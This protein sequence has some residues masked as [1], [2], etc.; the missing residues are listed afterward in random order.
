MTDVSTAIPPDVN[1]GP[2]ILA[3]CGSM[4]GL[5]LLVVGLRMWYRAVVRK[6]VAWDDYCMAAAMTVMF[7]EMMII[8]PEVVLGAGRHVQFI[9]PESNIAKGLHLNFVTQPLSIIA[10]CLTKVSVGLFLLRINPLPKFKRVIWA[11]IAFTVAASVAGVFTVLFQCRP[12]AFTWDPSTPGGHC[13]P[14]AN[15]RFAAFFN[16]SLSVLTDVIFSLLPIPMIWG[17]QL[18]WR[19]KAAIAALLSLG[20]FAA[21]ASI[22]RITYIKDYGKHG[23]FLFDS[24][25]L[26]IW[27][28]VEICVAIVAGSMPSLKPIVVAVIS[29]LSIGRASTRKRETGDGRDDW[30]SHKEDGKHGRGVDMHSLDRRNVALDGNYGC[31]EESAE[32][33]VSRQVCTTGE[34][35]GPAIDGPRVCETPHATV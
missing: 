13:I 4:V 34:G 6:N 17:V 10:L 9:K 1:R 20:L 3:V 25:N 2:Q 33:L 11:T 19:L 30:T 26:T 31:H 21:A 16:S 35:R 27:T 5:A 29:G 8:I 7:V 15:L 12:L 28:T 24:S 14:P 23:D 32:S 18:S 22:I